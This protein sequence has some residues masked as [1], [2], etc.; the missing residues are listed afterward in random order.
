MLALK[1]KTKLEATSIKEYKSQNH[2]C[3]E[4][5]GTVLR[6]CNDCVW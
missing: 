4:T 5:A 6:A 2:R 1:S 3:R